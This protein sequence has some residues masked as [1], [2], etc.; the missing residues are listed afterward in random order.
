MRA[1]GCGKILVGSLIVAEF[2]KAVREFGVPRGLQLG[3]LV[4][5]VLLD[6][7]FDRLGTRVSCFFPK[8][9]R[10]CAKRKACGM[11]YWRKGRRTHTV[12]GQQLVE[13]VEVF[14]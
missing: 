8:Q 10:R 14:P 1:F 3:D 13:G 5:V 12:L 11:P 2:R 9:S 6:H 7:S 4:A